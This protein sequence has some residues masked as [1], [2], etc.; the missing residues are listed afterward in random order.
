MRPTTG[1]CDERGPLIQFNFFI[2]IYFRKGSEFL[3]SIHDGKSNKN[4]LK[5]RCRIDGEAVLDVFYDASNRYSLT[6]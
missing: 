1:P 6:K 2:L 5:E 4:C 3:A